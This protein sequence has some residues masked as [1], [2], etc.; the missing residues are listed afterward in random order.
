MDVAPAAAALEEAGSPPGRVHPPGRARPRSTST[1]RAAP[2]AERHGHAA[3]LLAEDGADPD[4]VAAQLLLAAPEPW[5]VEQ[6]RTAARTALAR[7]APENAAAYLRHSLLSANDF[8]VRAALLRELAAAEAALQDPAAIAHLQ[9]AQ[10]LTDDPRRSAEIAGDLIELLVYAGEWDAAVSAIDAARPGSARATRSS[11]GS[12]RCGPRPPPTTRAA[13]RS[14]R[15]GWTNCAPRPQT[16][17]RMAVS[18]RSCWPRWTRA[19]AIAW[20]RSSSASTARSTAAAP[21]RR[22]GRGVVLPQAT[23]AL[24]FVDEVERSTALSEAMLRDARARGSV[25]GYVVASG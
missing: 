18:S 16:A 5:A 12:T 6:L 21:G 22:R 23:L 25:R 11:C 13:T 14:S 4:R 24:L 2:R 3:R 8:G 19:V 9:E 7:G 17:D 1:S 10:R 15:R 20:A